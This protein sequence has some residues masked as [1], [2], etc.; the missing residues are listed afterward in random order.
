MMSELRDRLDSNPDII[1]LV[2][3]PSLSTSDAAMGLC[4]CFEFVSNSLWL[5]WRSHYSKGGSMKSSCQ[6]LQI[7]MM[8]AAVGAA[9]MFVAC[10]QGTD[11]PEQKTAYTWSYDTLSAPSVHSVH[12]IWGSDIANL[13]MLTS[14]MMMRYDGRRFQTV[15]L[16]N[17]PGSVYGPHGTEYYDLDGD[18]VEVW[19]VGSSV[20]SKQGNLPD[21]SFMMHFDG[22]QWEEIDLRAGTALYAVAAAGNG[23]VYAAGQSKRIIRYARGTEEEILLPDELT[24]VPHRS[25]YCSDLSFAGGVL[26]GAGYLI[27]FDS[28]HRGYR[29]EIENGST[30]Y[31]AFFEEGQDQPRGGFWQNRSGTV[32]GRGLKNVYRKTGQAWVPMHTS[33]EGMM[34]IFGTTD[35]NIWITDAMNC[36]QY[37]DGKPRAQKPEAFRLTGRF[38]RGWTDGSTVFVVCSNAS[39]NHIVIATGK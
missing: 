20:R 15:Q 24:S 35:A 6:I 18:G 3:F 13:Y 10:E 9:S 2:P 23:V 8:V 22:T 19:A 21:S 29:F 1:I 14:D 16:S 27:D 33:E 11:P 7:V 5:A 25:L 37:V 12:V 26:Y 17:I 36:I 32:Y 34:D 28:A 4:P 39:S 31:F 30:R 38:G